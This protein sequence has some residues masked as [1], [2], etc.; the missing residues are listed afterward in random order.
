M[1]QNIEQHLDKFRGNSNIWI[2]EFLY[3]FSMLV[4]ALIHLRLMTELN[5]YIQ[6]SER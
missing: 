4:V 6:Q 3:Q 5:L 1:D 2:Q